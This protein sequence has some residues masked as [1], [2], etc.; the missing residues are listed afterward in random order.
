M[1][2]TG[3]DVP[4]LREIVADVLEDPRFSVLTM[5]KWYN[6]ITTTFRHIAG[7]PGSP[8]SH[9]TDGHRSKMS[10]S[11]T[12]SRK[13][14]QQAIDAEIK[15][16]QKSIRALT[17]RR[18]ALSPI[19]SLPPEIFEAIFTF[20]C[21]P[22]LEGKMS[23]HHQARLLVSHVCH[24]WR[25]IALNHP[26]LWS[27]I[28]F[29]NPSLAGATEILARV[30]SVPLYLEARVPHF[31]W[32]DAQFSTF[33]K[34]LQAHISD[35]CH[36]S[37]SAELIRLHKT[38]GGL[39][40]PAPTLEYLS[41]F[42]RGGYWNSETGDHLFIPDTLFRGSAPKLSRLK[43]FNCEISW[44][45]TLLKGLKHLEMRSPKPRPK[46]AAWLD[47]LDDMSQ[48]KTLILHSASPI[49]SEGDV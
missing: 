48:L 36:L 46:I 9:N 7:S 41:L 49:A 29:I 38:L 33:R 22:V 27:N 42:S 43:L 8:A 32:D 16:L 2:Y 21:L 28:D 3:T 40:S 47:A 31:N 11:Q 37:I 30:K 18:N 34:A 26:F 1:C 15:S 24:Q 4:L 45:S 19:S 14:L 35:V 13:H 12:N 17:L 6:L 39:T 44:S 25:E 10:P 5:S 20:L 23:D